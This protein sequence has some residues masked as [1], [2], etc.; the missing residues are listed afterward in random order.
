MHGDPEKEIVT[1]DVELKGSF[2]LKQLIEELEFQ[3][4]EGAPE[5][6]VLAHANELGE[7]LVQVK[8]EI[9]DLRQKGEIYVPRSG[10][11]R[12]I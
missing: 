6:A 10:Y 2:S 5:E 12:V 4:D 8:R 11:F 9:E 1:V 7:D 3:Y